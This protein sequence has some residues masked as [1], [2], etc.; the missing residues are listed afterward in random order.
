VSHEND[1]FLVRSA[2][3]FRL[4]RARRRVRSRALSLFL[5]A[6]ARKTSLGSRVARSG[7]AQRRRHSRKNFHRLFCVYIYPE[8]KKR[9]NSASARSFERGN[10][11]NR[12]NENFPSKASVS[13]CFVLF[14][15]LCD[16][17]K[18]CV[19]ENVR[20]SIFYFSHIYKH[21]YKSHAREKKE[22]IHYSLTHSSKLALFSTARARRGEK[23]CLLE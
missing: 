2:R 14:C 5:V 3:L 11:S 23:R 8:K 4:A 16:N 15:V 21:T 6:F 22:L 10:Q 18:I 1:G 17:L 19:P 7:C 20:F 13:F 12:R 9:T